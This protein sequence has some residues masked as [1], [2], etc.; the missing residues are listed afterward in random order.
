MWVPLT[1]FVESLVLLIFNKIFRMPTSG[2]VIAETPLT[3]QHCPNTKL[4]C[5]AKFY[6]VQKYNVDNFGVTQNI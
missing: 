5:L 6:A 4:L 3:S 2:Q 1:H